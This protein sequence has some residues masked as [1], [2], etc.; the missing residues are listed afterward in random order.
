MQRLSSQPL[1]ISLSD[2]GGGGPVLPRPSMEEGRLDPVKVP[3]SPIGLIPPGGGALQQHLGWDV[4]VWI[5]S[6][7]WVWLPALPL[8]NPEPVS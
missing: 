4:R 5:L 7:S 2:K 8:E 3:A 6:L 1:A